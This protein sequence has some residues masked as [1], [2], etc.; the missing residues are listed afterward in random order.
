MKTLWEKLQFRILQQVFI[1]LFKTLKNNPATRNGW[2]SK[3]KT[4]INTYQV[5]LECK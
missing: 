5:V 2:R 3:A 4:S 1:N